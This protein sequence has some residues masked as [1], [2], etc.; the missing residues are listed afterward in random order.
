V[1]LV[2]DKK[3]IELIY[4]LVN[5]FLII[6]LL[7]LVVYIFYRWSKR[8]EKFIE[9]MTIQKKIKVGTRNKYLEIN[10]KNA[11]SYTENINTATLFDL[12]Q[13]NNR[14]K[15]SVIKNND[16]LYLGNNKDVLSVSKTPYEAKDSIVY[17]D[18]NGKLYMLDEDGIAKYMTIYFQFVNNEQFSVPI[19]LI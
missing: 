13:V 1:K 2:L 4:M 10:D 9:M 15:I 12:E 14:Y 5:D 8:K 19:T 16:K 11:L 7:L 18:T 17:L 3:N 6:I